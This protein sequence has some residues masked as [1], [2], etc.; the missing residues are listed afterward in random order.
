MAFIPLYDTNP[1]RRIR[2]PWV[3]W[4]IIAANVI[5]YFFFESGSFVAEPKN[6]SS[7]SFAP[8]AFGVQ[9]GR[10]T[11][12]PW[13]CWRFRAGLT[14]VSYA[15]LH[16]D[17]WHLAGNMIFLWVFGDNVEDALGHFRYF[18]F[19]FVCAAVSGYAFVLSDPSSDSPVIGASGAVAGTLAAYLL[20]Y[21]RAKVWILLLFRI[22]LRL[23]VEYVLGFW[24]AFQIYSAVVGSDDQ[25]AWWVHLG[26]AGHR[27][28]PRAFHAAEGRA[29]V[30]QGA[31]RASMAL[32]GPA[33]CRGAAGGR[34][35][36]LPTNR[37]DRGG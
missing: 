30:R 20:L 3:A 6:A 16:A 28:H 19:Y 9:R 18:I 14:L 4:G 10:T 21:P 37:K 35:R 24:V 33:G 1:L 13:T 34:M 25:V 32:A 12:P 22:P 2:W 29:P 15:F 7:I 11:R 26:G 31:A 5:V 8:G 27:R 23:R 36:R 17:F